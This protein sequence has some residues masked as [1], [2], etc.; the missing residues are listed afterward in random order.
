MGPRHIEAE[1]TE[2]KKTSGRVAVGRFT[3]P[4]SEKLRRPAD[5]NRVY[6]EGKKIGDAR[7]ALFFGP[8]ASENTRLGVSVS[9]R[10]GN[11]VTRNRVKRLLREAFRLNKHRM[12]KGYDLLFVARAGVRDLKFRQVEAV[13]MEL[14][15]RGELLVERDNGT[16]NGGPGVSGE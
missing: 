15:R 10:I 1:K 5:F 16:P 9:K 4:R 6:S 12:K 14:L 8:F 2:R 13:V 11:A 7:L 3:L